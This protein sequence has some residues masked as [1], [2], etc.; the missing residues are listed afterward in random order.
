MQ[1]APTSFLFVCPGIV[2]LRANTSLADAMLDRENAGRWASAL[3]CYDQA[4]QMDP[5]NEEHHLGLLKC[6]R[7][8]GHLQTMVTHVDGL[9]DAATPDLRSAAVAAAWRLGRWEAVEDNA[10]K[11]APT[12]E[13]AVGRALLALK[14]EKVPLCNDIIDKARKEIM[15][16]LTAARYA[17][18]GWTGGWSLGTCQAAT[19]TYRVCLYVCMSVCLS[20][21][22]WSHISAPTRSFRS[23]TSCERSR[24]PSNAS[25]RMT[26]P[27]AAALPPIPLATGPNACRSP[28]RRSRSE[29][30]F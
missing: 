5:L 7:N 6:L 28:S 15:N 29:R 27:A 22:V 25:P 4:L 2:K 14:N 20:C 18:S 30:R 1:Q 3:S 12:F 26:R 10:P 19:L 23:C 24:T 11:A 17:Q 13:V 21:T 9:G 8:L 16:P